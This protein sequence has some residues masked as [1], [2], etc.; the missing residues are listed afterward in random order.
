[1]QVLCYYSY[2]DNKKRPYHASVMLFVDKPEHI[3]PAFDS[4]MKALIEL[5]SPKIEE[6]KTELGPLRVVLENPIDDCG[7]LPPLEYRLEKYAP[8]CGR[9][10]W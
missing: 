7:L 2:V 5:R 9:E 1:M 10:I 4:K 3:L 8:R 6:T